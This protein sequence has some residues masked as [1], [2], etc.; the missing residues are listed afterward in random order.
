MQKQKTEL[1]AVVGTVRQLES[2]GLTRDAA[3]DAVVC[4]AD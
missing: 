2:D 1:N 3:I 4:L